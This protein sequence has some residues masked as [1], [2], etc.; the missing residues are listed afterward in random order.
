[1]S[2]YCSYLAGDCNHKCKLTPKWVA[3][4]K[5]ECTLSWAATPFGVNLHFLSYKYN[6]MPTILQW[7]LS[8]LPVIGEANPRINTIE[9][10]IAFKAGTQL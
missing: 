1:M 8:F 2:R 4:E 3:A 7:R 9:Q 6:S 5:N 10:S